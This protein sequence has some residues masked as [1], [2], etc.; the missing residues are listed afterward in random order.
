M[1]G[2][3]TTKRYVGLDIRVN[4]VGDYAGVRPFHYQNTLVEVLHDHVRIW[5]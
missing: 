3:T 5:E 4:L 2:H 1:P